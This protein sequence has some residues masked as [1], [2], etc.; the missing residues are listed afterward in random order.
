MSKVHSLADRCMRLNS[1]VNIQIHEI[2][3]D[4]T[5]ALDIIKKYDVIMDCS[6]NLANT[7]PLVPMKRVR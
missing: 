6:D 7:L 5:N 1:T 4:N 2:H 3:L